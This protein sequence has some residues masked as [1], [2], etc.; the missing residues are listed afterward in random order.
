MFI[1]KHLLFKF[2]CI[3]NNKLTLN[4]H[5]QPVWEDRTV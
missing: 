1:P 3:D 2:E 4:L 5:E